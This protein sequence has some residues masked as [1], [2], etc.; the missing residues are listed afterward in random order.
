MIKRMLEEISEGG[1][2]KIK[3]QQQGT[4][5]WDISGDITKD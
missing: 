4:L 1:I 3:E 2:G 5:L